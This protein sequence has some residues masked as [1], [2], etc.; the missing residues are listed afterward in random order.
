MINELIYVLQ[1]TFTETFSATLH[2]SIYTQLIASL[3]VDDTNWNNKLIYLHMVSLWF[4][5]HNKDVT[6]FFASF[7]RFK[8]LLVKEQEKVAALKEK[9]LEFMAEILVM[10]YHSS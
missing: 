10:F 1:K 5:M 4:C 7:E 6:L 9:L 8:A 3:S 2:I